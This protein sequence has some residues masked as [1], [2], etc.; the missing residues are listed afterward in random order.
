[1]DNLQTMLILNLTPDSFSDGGKYN[2]IN[3]LDNY[4]YNCVLPNAAYIDYID[5]GAESTR[6]NADIIS[7]E[8]EWERLYPVLKKYLPIF[9]KNNIKVSID[10]YKADI[11]YKCLNL[12]SNIFAINNINH[13][14]TSKILQINSQ[15]SIQY[16]GMSNNTFAEYTDIIDNIKFNWLSILDEI[17]NYSNISLI[18]LDP[19]FGFVNNINDNWII[20]KNIQNL[21]NFVQEQ[22]Q[23]IKYKLYLKDKNIQLLAGISRKRFIKSI[24]QEQYQDTGTDIINY[25]L[26]RSGVSIIRTHNIN[27]IVMLKKYIQS[28]LKA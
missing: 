20:L 10:S 24:W 11:I 1:M 16:I 2:S 15:Y 3:T 26:I 25:E 13:C 27:N 19:G 5:I 18:F 17:K 23:D 21:Y 7:S 8:C 4:I 12:D 22:K 6:P 14:N 28:L 9:H